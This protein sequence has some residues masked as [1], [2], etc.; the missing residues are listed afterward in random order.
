M[1]NIVLIHGTWCTGDVWGESVKEF[2]K[3]GF[4]VY[5]PTLRNHD[6]PFD[7]VM[8]KVATVSLADYVDDIVELINGLEGQTIVLGHSLGG[9]I[10]QLVAQRINVAGVILLGTA[11]TAGIFAFYPTMVI[12]FYKH[13]LRYGFWKKAM[14]P[15]KH[16]FC[17]YCMNEQDPKDK[18]KEF[19]KLVPESGFVYF[20]MALPFLDKQKGAYVDHEKIKVPVL[21]I[22]GSKD[23]MV[24]PNIAKA[25]F[26]KYDRA[27]LVVLHGSDHMYLATKYREKTIMEIKDWLEE[28]DLI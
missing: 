25:T 4:R 2:E 27:K 9:L 12:C 3:L 26:R 19:A 14:P 17:D 28:N 6:L 13:F 18:D 11:P 22:T 10:A 23:K 20:Q 15:Y 8:E 24:H 21:I 5:T 16:A 7:E 1:K